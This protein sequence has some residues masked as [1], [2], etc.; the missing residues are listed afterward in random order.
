MIRIAHISTVDLTVRFLLLPEL[1]RLREEGFDVTAISAPGPWLEEVEAA[2]IRHIPW[3]HAT[4]AWDPREDIAAF[5]ELLAILRRERF[6]LVHT[7]TPK[8][9]ALGR[10]AARRAG[11]TCVVNTVHGFYVQPGDRAL[12]KL[13]VL[14]AER[15]AARSSDLELYQS[16]EDLA[17]A[18]RLRIGESARRIHLG[19][20]IDL[21]EFAPERVD[22]ERRAALR[23]ELGIPQDAVVVGTVCRLVAEKGVRELLQAA[24]ALASRQVRFL[25]VGPAE[26]GKSDAI[27]A[28]EIARAT[29]EGVVF[30]GAREDVLDLYAVMDVFV[31]ASWREGLPTSVIEGLAM[32]KPLVLTDIRGSREI[33]H[34]GVEALIVPP[35]DAERLTEAIRRL[36]DDPALRSRLGAAARARAV[37]RFDQRRVHGL[38]VGEYRRLLSRKGLLPAAD[39]P[40]RVRPAALDDLPEVAKLHRESLPSAFMSHLGEQFLRHF[41]RALVE[42]ER[43]LVIVADQGGTVTAFSAATTSMRHFSR[44][45]YVRHGLPAALAAA[46]ALLR[47]GVPRGLL[48]AAKYASRSDGLPDAEFISIGVARPSRRTGAGRLV[49]LE[50]LARLEGLGVKQVTFFTSTSNQAVSAFLRDLG[51]RP[52]TQIAVHRGVPSTVWITDLPS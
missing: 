33:A 35:R 16:E 49:A 11:A 24:S 51:F 36:V 50:T 38:L 4:R 28:D 17:W 45:F 7:H 22:A 5:R 20:G 1:V 25:V 41:Y 37:D 40:L 43:S 32:G 47:S 52:S 23:N 9:A 8:A 30:T 26:P 19:G 14:G 12:K 18:R 48:E 3:R 34:N 6:D 21:E 29:A 46:R 27:G 2:G 31:L 10:I 13:A 39:D 44:R 15:I 42:D